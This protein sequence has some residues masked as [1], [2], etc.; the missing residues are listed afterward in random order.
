MQEQHQKAEG[1]PVG[2]SSNEQQQFVTDQQEAY[3]YTM[4]SLYV[5]DLAPEVRTSLSFIQPPSCQKNLSQRNVQ[6]TEAML[7]EKFSTIGAIP[8]IRVC[9]DMVTR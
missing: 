4:G 7:F 6:V 5:G 8:S 9:R 1:G 2:F 3:N